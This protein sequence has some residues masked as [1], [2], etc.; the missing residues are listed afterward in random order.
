[1]NI[2][3]VDDEQLELD[4]LEYM[5]LQS[6]H[7]H[8]LYKAQDVSEALIYA[9]ANTVHLALIDIHLPGRSGLDL[10]KL[11]K[12]THKDINVVMVTAYQSF[13]YAQKALRLKV[14]NFITKP[15]VESE[16]ISAVKPFFKNNNTEMIQKVLDYVHAHYDSNLTLLYIASKEI[17]V[18][19]A[20]LSRKFNEELGMSFPR[21]L[22]QYRIKAAKY[23]MDEK[24]SLSI[25]EVSEKC[26]FSNQHYF[27]QLFKNETD[28]NPSVYRKKIPSK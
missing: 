20:Y 3:L 18:N 16:L 22:N 1:M 5:L 13:D 9:N 21:Y 6:F 14:D 25:E 26:G 24:P 17:H 8:T 12:Q 27:S 15:V 7:L 2:L 10:V 23:L 28:V 11:L 4:Q 19:Y